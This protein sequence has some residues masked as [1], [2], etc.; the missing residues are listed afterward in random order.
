MV[1][2][3]GGMEFSIRFHIRSR[4]N[5]IHLSYDLVILFIP[6]IFSVT[7]HDLLWHIFTKRY[8]NLEHAEI[9]NDT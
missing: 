1:L 4:S 8:T 5:F 6:N 2:V 7:F 3:I 9:E